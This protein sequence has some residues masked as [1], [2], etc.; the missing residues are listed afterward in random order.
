MAFFVPSICWASIAL[1]TLHTVGLEEIRSWADRRISQMAL[2]TA[3]FHIFILIDVGLINRFGKSPASFTPRGIALNL[4]VVSTTLLGTELSRAYL[5]KSL[6]RKRPILNLGLITILYTLINVSVLALLKFGD[7]LAYSEFLGIGFLPILTENLLAT[8]LALLSGPLASLA[9]RAPLQAFQWFSPILPD[10]P[11][12]YEALVGVMVPTIGFIVISQYTTPMLLRK[13]GI[14]T[15]TRKPKRYTRSEKSSVKGW[16]IVSV[17]CVLMV[18]SSTGLLGFFPSVIGSGSMR[19]TMDVGDLGIVISTDT[20]K[21]QVGD[22]IQFWN[23]EEMILH[24]VVDIFGERDVRIFQTQGDG[25]PTPDLDPILPGQIR[26]KLVLI[27]PKLGWASIYVK[28]AIA[29]TRSFFL[30]N[31]LTVYGML[32][33]LTLAASIYAIRTYK[34]RPCIRWQRRRGW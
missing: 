14:R 16:T 4:L 2:L 17:L 22:I 32:A 27:I 31:T 23:G 30:A 3:A 34:N 29:E 8:Y 10:L 6:N 9:Y 26:G 7:P 15:R 21:I 13:I 25:N 5:I 24:R 20:S 33:A 11:W 18:W 1:A 28:T 12:G 19:P